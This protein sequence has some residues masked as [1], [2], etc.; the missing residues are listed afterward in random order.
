M[1][2]LDIVKRLCDHEKAFIEKSEVG[3]GHYGYCPDCE[4]EGEYSNYEL[5]AKYL[6]EL[7]YNMAIT[8]TKH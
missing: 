8:R 7:K 5:E 2:H 4:I 1:D 6:F 3:C